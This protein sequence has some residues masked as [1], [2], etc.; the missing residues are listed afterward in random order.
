MAGTPVA[1]CKAT[2][3]LPP[4]PNVTGPLLV[5]APTP[6]PLVPGEIVPFTI[7]PGDVILEANQT[8]VNSVAEFGKVLSEDASKKGVVLLLIKR[9][10]QNLFRTVPLPG[11]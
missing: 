2:V 1:F 4:A 11:K 10:K 3:K 8:P 6:T 9:G 7:K 5:I